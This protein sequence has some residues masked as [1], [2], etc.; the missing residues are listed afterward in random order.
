MW[1]WFEGGD[2]AG[3]VLE[4]APALGIGGRVLGEDLEGDV[5]LETGVAGAVNLAHPPGPEGAQ[6][7]VG[8]ETAARRERHH[9]DL[10]VILC[11][12]VP[13]VY[14]NSSG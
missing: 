8:T 13:S 5:A 4:A 10:A 6:D 11:A 9:A 2:G 7:L 12:V 3:L 1:G 14:P